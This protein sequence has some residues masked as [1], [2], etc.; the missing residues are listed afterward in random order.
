[1]LSISITFL[2]KQ[3]IHVQRKL[4]ALKVIVLIKLLHVH[5]VDVACYRPV[6]SL[7]SNNRIYEL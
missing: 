2:V 7:Y 6:V 5:I 1:M 4:L 3:Y